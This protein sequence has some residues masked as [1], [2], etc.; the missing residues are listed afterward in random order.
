[1]DA[2]V[3][4]RLA[5]ALWRFWSVRGHWNEGR[6]WL[7]NAL[8]QHEAMSGHVRVEVLK[9]AGRLAKYQGDY[10]RVAS[11]AEELLALSR[12][13]G[14]TPGTAYALLG[15]SDAATALNDHQRASIAAEEAL[16]LSCVSGDRI[17]TAAAL[18][19][20]Y[21]LA[22]DRADMSRAS[23]LAEELLALSQQT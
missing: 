13:L 11:L 14:D 19:C 2:K 4:S 18:G 15:L 9:G 7:D 3:M 6:R 12:E 23:T 22:E 21:D 1:G 20:L 17:G 8:S 5:G 16:A 10:K